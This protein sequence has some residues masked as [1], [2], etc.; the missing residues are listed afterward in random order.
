MEPMS[1]AQLQIGSSICEIN[2]SVGIDDTG[3]TTAQLEP[4]LQQG[5]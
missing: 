1:E 4:I 2:N 5:I 3:Q